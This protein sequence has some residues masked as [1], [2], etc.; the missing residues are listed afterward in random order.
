MKL[1]VLQAEVRRGDVVSNLSTVKRL[2]EESKEEINLLTLPELFVTGYN[3]RD[4]LN[5]V[6]ETIPG[7]GPA[8]SGLC[9]L[10][11]SHNMLSLIHI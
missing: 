6:A 1:A 3:L 11:A 10:A 2:V 7:N 5:D 8:L 4:G 9:D